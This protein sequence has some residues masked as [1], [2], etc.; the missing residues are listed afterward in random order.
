M[1]LAPI[2]VQRQITITKLITWIYCVM[3]GRDAITI[4]MHYLNTN[5]ILNV[6]KNDSQN[7]ID[8]AYRCSS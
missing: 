5:G 2:I 6:T 1:A 7:I 4:M 8:Y 3:F